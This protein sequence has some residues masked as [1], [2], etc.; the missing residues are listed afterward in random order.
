MAVQAK[1][2]ISRLWDDIAKPPYK[3]LFHAGVTGPALWDRVQALRRID[4]AMQVASKHFIGRDALICVH[5]NR[6]IEWVV[7]Q[8]LGLS[9]VNRFATL[10]SSIPTRVQ[11]AVER[12]I[13]AV[14]A[15]FADSYPAS[16][17]KNLSKCRILATMI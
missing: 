3:T 2:E 6:F 7:M 5:G 12:T 8:Q 11:G 10:E 9:D 4:A 15:E 14:K 16:L 13:S 17:F 1:R